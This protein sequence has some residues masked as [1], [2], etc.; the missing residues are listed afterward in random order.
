MKLLFMIY[1]LSVLQI[2][3]WVDPEEQ[4]E[5]SHEQPADRGDQL[6]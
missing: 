1:L 5:G 2:V 3:V 4:R 6:H